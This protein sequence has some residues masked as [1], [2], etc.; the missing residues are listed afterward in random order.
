MYSVI[1][2]G[3]LGADP[4]IGSKFSQILNTFIINVMLGRQSR[5][6]ERAYICNYLNSG[7]GEPC[8]GQMRPWD[9]EDPIIK[10]PKLTDEEVNLGADELT[11]SEIKS[12]MLNTGII[13]T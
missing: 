11:G 6:E 2:A 5:A 4:E 7:F 13:N 12:L 3:N 9:F 8:A 10:D 1:L